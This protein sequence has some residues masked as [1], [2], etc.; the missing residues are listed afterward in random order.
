ME[1]VLPVEDNVMIKNY[2]VFAFV[3]G[4]LYMEDNFSE[5]YVLTNFLRICPEYKNFQTVK[6]SIYSKWKCLITKR[7]LFL[8]EKS[9]IDGIKSMIAQ[10]FYV[11]LN[12]NQKYIPNRIAFQKKSFYHD[13]YIAGV[14]DTRQTFYVYG[15]DKNL[16][17]TKQEI[18]FRT[19]YN[20]YKKSLTK[21]ICYHYQFKAKSDYPYQA[22]NKKKIACD[23]IYFYRKKSKYY[24][25][26]LYDYLIKDLQSMTKINLSYYRYLKE[27]KTI[28]VR[29]STYF[30][31]MPQFN[32]WNQQILDLA[33][34][35]FAYV[36]K[37]QLT[38]Q[39][40]LREEI[41]SNLRKMKSLETNIK[42]EYFNGSKTE[43]LKAL[44]NCLP[45]EM[46]SK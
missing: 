21:F 12:I 16:Q 8:T 15:Y 13:N 35:T 17:F 23:L 18:G 46:P 45:D 38:N 33:E 40:E 4:I 3:L 10:G 42:I 1:Y 43:S 29:F 25:L 41:I 22:I 26:H 44:L 7:F 11:V 36:L 5:N 39:K 34:I 9:F 27:Y 30:E 24:G 20:S 2:G 31:A 32:Q 28:L 6:W 37:L 19:L 14:N